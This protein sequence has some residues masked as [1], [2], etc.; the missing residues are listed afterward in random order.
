MD[1]KRL[2]D[3]CENNAFKITSLV[4]MNDLWWTICAEK[5]VTM[6]LAVWSDRRTASAHIIL[7]D[8]KIL[9]IIG[10]KRNLQYVYSNVCQGGCFDMGYMVACAASTVLLKI[11]CH[12]DPVKAFLCNFSKVLSTPWWPT[13]GTLAL[14][15][16][17]A[18]KEEGQVQW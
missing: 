6:W 12:V 8:K 3:L 13:V 17:T 10:R 7:Q 2:E 16:L 18:E 4:G 14:M 9:A 11:L 15:L 5:P 1:A